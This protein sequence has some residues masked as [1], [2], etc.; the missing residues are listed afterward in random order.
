MPIND[1]RFRRLLDENKGRLERLA[2]QYSDPADWQDLLQDIHVQLWLSLKNFDGRSQ[3][4]TW[5]YRVALNTAISVLRKRRLPRTSK[6]PDDVGDS[7]ATHDSM[8]V[9]RE[10]LA[11]LESIDRALLLMDLEGMPRDQIA[12]VL[13]LSSGA[14]AVR[15]TRLKQ[16]FN[17]QY[18]EP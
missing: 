2:R 6:A 1:E 13:C 5:V 8:D 16:Q 4:S 12:E 14:V 15:M 3:L 7:G 10:F 17:Q 18:L 9:L 11:S